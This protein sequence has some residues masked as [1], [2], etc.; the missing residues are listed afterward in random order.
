MCVS[1]KS[2]ADQRSKSY[3]PMLKRLSRKRLA[4][5]PTRTRRRSRMSGY[6]RLDT[7]DAY[8]NRISLVVE[9]SLTFET[10][11]LGLGI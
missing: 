10:Q 4:P 9:F 3:L 6:R 5:L 1:M 8:L 11:I 7:I 2:L